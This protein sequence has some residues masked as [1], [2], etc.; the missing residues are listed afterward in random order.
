MRHASLALAVLL[1][2]CGQGKPAAEAAPAAAPAPSR[3]AQPIAPGEL[4]ETSIRFGLPIDCKLGETCEIQNYFD[5]DP[6]P[7]VVDYRCQARTYATH[8]GIDIRIPDMAAQRAGVAVLAAAPGKVTRL[9]DGVMDI[10]IRA[11]GAPSVAGQQCGNGVVIDHGGGWETQYCHL[12]QGSVLVKQ[13]DP[14]TAGQPIAKV[15]LS[16]DTEF[17]HLHFTVRR[18]PT[19]L[20][21]FDPDP[22]DKACAARG[23]LW[24]AQAYQGLRYKEGVV[25]NSGFSSGAVTMG[26]I[27]EATVA[28]AHAGGEALVAYARAIGLRQG[29][30]VELTLTGPGGSVLAHSR[31]APLDHDK[32]Q[33]FLFVGRKAPAGGWPQGVYVARYAVHRAGTVAV[34]R[35]F[36]QTL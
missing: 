16:G 7:G 25:L 1:A 4:T 30:E 32:A 18:G 34:T 2:A 3:A 22:A 5:R 6:G 9:R 23:A 26:A 8:N 20:D 14:V 28:P 17:P 12:A 36:Q 21:P 35:Q 33:H 29:D 31:M 10:S 19:A 13:G 15:G 27:E 11:P 24:T